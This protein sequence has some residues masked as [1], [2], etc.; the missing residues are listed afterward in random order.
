M[1]KRLAMSLRSSSI[2]PDTSIR[3]NITAWVAGAEEFLARELEDEV[4]L[5]LAVLARL[6]LAGAVA[7]AA[8]R[9]LDAVSGAELVVAREDLLP[10]AAL[11]VVQGGLGEVARGDGDLLAILQVADGAAMDG[12]G[13]RLAD[14]LLEAAHEALAVHR[15]L[16]LAVE[17]PIDDA[18]HV[19]SRCP[20]PARAHAARRAPAGP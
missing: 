6:A 11:A 3:Q 15:A 5:V 8:E 1:K 7:T 4:V 16:V 2:E 12:L 10:H 19:S 9:T 20:R 18:D 17:A 13:H 14:L